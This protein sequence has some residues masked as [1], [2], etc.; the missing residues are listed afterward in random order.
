MRLSVPNPS[1]DS[2]RLD[3]ELTE[4]GQKIEENRNGNTRVAGCLQSPLEAV[5]HDLCSRKG[6][7]WA[8]FDQEVIMEE[9]LSRRVRAGR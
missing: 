3:G 1:G 8:Y 9:D 7:S 4:G 6:M 2:D 5:E